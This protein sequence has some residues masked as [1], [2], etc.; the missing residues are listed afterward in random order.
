MTGKQDRAW[1]DRRN[2]RVRRRRAELAASCPVEVA[3][4]K[5]KDAA[6]KRL[7]RSALRCPHASRE[8][9][10]TEADQVEALT[11]YIHSEENF[12]VAKRRNPT[13]DKLSTFLS[14]RDMQRLLDRREMLTD[15]I[16]DWHCAVVAQ[17]LGVDRSKVRLMGSATAQI[18]LGEYNFDR[19]KH[20][21][22][23]KTET[24]NDKPTSVLDFEKVVFP[25]CINEHWVV[26]SLEPQAKRIYLYDSLQ[27]N[28][29]RFKRLRSLFLRY[30]RDHGS[31]RYSFR[32]MQEEVVQQNNSI[33]CGVYVADRIAAILGANGGQ[34]TCVDDLTVSTYRARMYL[35]A[36]KIFLL[37][38]KI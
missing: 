16:L 5:A 32:F 9:D 22:M 27:N 21:H 2:E 11:T 25:V 30:A 19:I 37:Q 4:R 29:N 34:P 17:G 36:L 10:D 28:T 23:S 24:K 8:L 7:K 26:V 20:D 38:D 35:A 15:S 13:T 31:D 12:T 6:R 14:F 1:R 3:K 33:D 18:M